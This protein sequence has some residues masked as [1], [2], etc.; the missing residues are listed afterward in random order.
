MRGSG[1]EIPRRH[2]RASLHDV[3]VQQENVVR[4]FGT[5]G[6]IIVPDPWMPHGEGGKVKIIVE[7]SGRQVPWSA[8]SLRKRG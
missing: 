5:E 1:L 4:V 6:R 3:S 8:P 7:V 2:C